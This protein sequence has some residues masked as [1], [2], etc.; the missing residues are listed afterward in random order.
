MFTQEA[1]IKFQKWFVEPIDKLKELPD[2]SGGFIALMVGLVL[3]ERFIIA[4]LKTD[5]QKA[6][7]DAIKESMMK[8]LRLSKKQ[9]QIFW[10]MFRNGLLHQGMPKSGRTGYWFHHSFSGY[11]E[12]VIENGQNYICIDPWKFTDR[13]IGYFLSNPDLLSVSTS[14]PFPMI[15]PP[16]KDLNVD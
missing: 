6:I 14:F 15:F 5:D 16:R 3:Y 8:D 2:G 7:K 10:D 12:F 4:K 1:L 13:V 9:Q 11:P